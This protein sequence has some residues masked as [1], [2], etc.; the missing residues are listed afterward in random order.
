MAVRN[1]HQLTGVSSSSVQGIII[2]VKVIKKNFLEGSSDW[3]IVYKG[4]QEL[5]I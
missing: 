3:G 2:V 1:L 4:C 5:V